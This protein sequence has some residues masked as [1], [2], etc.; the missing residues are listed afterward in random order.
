MWISDNLQ[1]VFLQSLGQEGTKT[2]DPAFSDLFQKIGPISTDKKSG[3]FTDI[4]GW[5]GDTADGAACQNTG[6]AQPR[7]PIELGSFNSTA[8][9]AVYD[10]FAAGIRE[11]PAFGESIVLIWAQSLQGI[12]AVPSD[13]TAY[14]FR[15]DNITISTTIKYMPDGPDLDKKAAAL[16]ESIRQ[17]FYKSSGREELHAY[18]NYAYGTE[19]TKTTFGYEPWRQEKLR[20]LKAK[21]DPKGRFNFYA[22]IA[23]V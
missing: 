22:P 9:R 7:F 14:A 16:G 10:Q 11:T 1:P 2:V 5:V 17:I 13:S 19:T 20:S 18:V 21:Y 3:I 15:A 12:K 8:V 4:A 23:L 6:A